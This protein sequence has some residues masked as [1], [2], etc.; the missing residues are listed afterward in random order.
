MAETSTIILSTRQIAILAWIKGGCPEGVYEAED[1]SHRISARALANKG[2]VK[3]SGRGPSWTAVPTSRGSVWPAATQDDEIVRAREKKVA[4]IEAQAA[5]KRATSVGGAVKPDNDRRRRAKPPRDPNRAERR[6]LLVDQLTQKLI[7]T[8]EPVVLEHEEWDYGEERWIESAAI[9]SP[10]RPYGKVLSAINTGGWTSQQHTFKFVKYLPDF[11]DR[12]EVAVPERVSRYRPQVRE[13]L[14]DKDGQWVS[15]S[16]VPRAARILNAIVTELERRGYEGLTYD[17][18]AIAFSTP[19]GA[20]S[21]QIRE[22]GKWGEYLMYD[23]RKRMEARGVPAW[24]YSKGRVFSGSNRLTLYLGKKDWT[25]SRSSF[26]DAKIKRVES[27][28]P[29]AFF[30][31]ELWLLQNIERAEAEKLRE[32]EWLRK[33]EEAKGKAVIEYEATYKKAHFLALMQAS[34]EIAK[35]RTFLSEALGVLEHLSEQDKEAAL[36]YLREIEANLDASDPLLKPEMFLPKVPQPSAS[37][38]EPF[39]R[40]YRSARSLWG[41]DA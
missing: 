28:L 23:D 31:F 16:L 12:V 8:G 5:A 32:Q 22:Q 25:H 17:Q 29:D 14:E 21:F 10:N 40:K 1:T 18:G 38:L 19:F 7:D 27:R 11:I 34:V 33:E 26:A 9:R 13:F 15:P 2:L 41:H 3:V 24:R 4:A 30:E 36:R 6:Q 20:Y 35:R 39:L 37:D